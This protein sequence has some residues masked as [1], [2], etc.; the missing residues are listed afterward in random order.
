MF[1]ICHCRDLRLLIASC[2][3]AGPA[4][5]PSVPAS[6]PPLLGPSD[7]PGCRVTRIHAG[8]T[9][10]PASSAAPQRPTRSS[11]P[12]RSRHQRTQTPQ[13]Q[14]PIITGA[15]FHW[16]CVCACAC[17]AAAEA[18]ACCWRACLRCEAQRRSVWPMLVTA[19]GERVSAF[20]CSCRASD[21]AAVGRADC[22]QSL[23]IGVG[24]HRVK[25]ALPMA[26]WAHALACPWSVSAMSMSGA[27]Q[28]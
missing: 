18:C 14:Y 26:A 3:P 2:D 9:A 28:C 27:P 4:L 17:W 21:C 1:H 10:T 23:W 19:G 13:F 24:G 20:G 25:R 6:V 12:R 11:P 5:R 15:N 22:F 16:A 8:S 7:W